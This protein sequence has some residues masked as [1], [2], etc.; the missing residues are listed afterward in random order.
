MHIAADHVLTM[1]LQCA[2]AQ[3]T[4]FSGLSAATRHVLSLAE[5]ASYEHEPRHSHLSGKDLGQRRGG[6][7]TNGIKMSIRRDTINT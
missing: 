3:N 2:H 6:W 4:D 7:R 5:T 1:S